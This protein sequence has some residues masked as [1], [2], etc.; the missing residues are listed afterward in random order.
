MYGIDGAEGWVWAEHNGLTA[1]LAF[2]HNLAAIFP[3]ALHAARPEF[4]PLVHGERLRPRDGAHNW[5]PD[6][7]RE[8][9]ATWAADAARRHFEANPESEVFSVGVNDGLIFGESPETLAM[10]R[11]KIP[12]VES[13]EPRAEGGDRPAF[14]PTT[15]DTDGHGWNQSGVRNPEQ[16]AERPDQDQIGHRGPGGVD[17]MARSQ[18]EDMGAGAAESGAQGSESVSIRAIRGADRLGAG[19]GWFRGRPDFS[20]LVFGFTNRVAE[21]LARTHPDKYVGA[22]AYYWCE[23]APDFPLEPNVIPFLTADRSQG[24]DEAFRAEEAALQRRWA[25]AHRCQALSNQ[26]RADHETHG[27]HEN[28]T[29]ENEPVASGSALRSIPTPVEKGGRRKREEN[30]TELSAKARSGEGRSKGLSRSSADGRGTADLSTLSSQ[31]S[32]GDQARAAHETHE[33]DTEAAAAQISGFSSQVSA[34]AE[35]RLGL[36]DYL[37]GGGFL[38]PRIHTRLIADNLRQARRLGFTDYFAEVSPN[39]GLDGPMPWLVAQLL[40]DPEQSREVLLEEYYTRWFG[41][42]AVPMRRFFE[43]CEQQWMRQPGRAY[44]LKHYRN[45]SQAQLFPS[46]VCRELRGLLDEAARQARGDAVKRR[47][48]RLSDAFGATE[49]FVAFCEA[50][51]GLNREQ[52]RADTRTA[53]TRT[54]GRKEAQKAQENGVSAEGENAERA[55]VACY[56]AAREEFITYTRTLIERQPQVLAPFRWEDYLR[57]EPPLGDGKRRPEGGDLK[58]ECRNLRP[59]SGNR[60]MRDNERE[61]EDSAV[62]SAN[63]LSNGDMRGALVQPKRI[64]GL[65]YGVAMP[66]GWITTVEP[67]EGQS[68]R[69]E[70]G[71]LRLERNKETFVYQWLAATGGARYRATVEVRGRVQPSA[72]ASLTLSWLDERQTPL[73]IK[74][75]RLPEGVWPEWVTLEVAQDLP[76]TARWIGTGVRVQ[77]QL[78]G[79]WL[80]ARNFR[81]EKRAVPG[82][83]LWDAKRDKGAPAQ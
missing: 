79:D 80:E 24:Y 74:V 11:K 8:D 55:E 50:R 46:E 59:G 71:V 6:L 67:A 9:V 51:D 43:R 21:D 2:S 15:D 38:I 20:N 10:M 42:A 5:N 52:L 28:Q 49:R 65:D 12:S 16:K 69:V 22:L 4:F 72:T 60:G 66:E 3:P 56:R 27:T 81:L 83:A 58:P 78:E 73:G 26:D 63:L 19:G 36:Y 75:H 68:A 77:H 53:D 48:Q 25:A 45:E 33:R 82:L 29:E 7:G 14:R 41:D 61:G 35:R 39:W 47:V 13:P 70:D 32:T 62:E 1:P 17:S 31:R 57:H 44:W 76:A 30:G 40:Q 34:G 18:A 23:N 64:G 54:I 37:Y